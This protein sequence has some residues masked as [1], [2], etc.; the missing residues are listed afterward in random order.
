ME[1]TTPS[2][3][4]PQKTIHLWPMPG[5]KYMLWDEQDG[6]QIKVKVKM[7]LLTRVQL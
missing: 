2:C 1:L 4:A 3:P 5:I 7:K 6:I